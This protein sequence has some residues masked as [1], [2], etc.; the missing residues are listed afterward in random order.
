MQNLRDVTAS[1]TVLYSLDDATL[2]ITNDCND[3]TI[4]YRIFEFE[5]SKVNWRDYQLTQNRDEIIE[6]NFLH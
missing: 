5:E 6:K 4:E 2:K 1:A 3:Q